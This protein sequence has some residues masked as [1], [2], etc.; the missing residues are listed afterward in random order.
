MEI[1]ERGKESIPKIIETR[2]K[3]ISFQD[4]IENN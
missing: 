3:A 4:T 2:L 1:K